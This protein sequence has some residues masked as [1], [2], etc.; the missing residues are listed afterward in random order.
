MTISISPKAGFITALSSFIARISFRIHW[1]TGQIWVTKKGFLRFF[2]K[3]IDKIIFNFSNFVLV[4]SESQKQFL[5]LNNIITNDK[6]TVLLNGSVG[7]VNIKKFKYKKTNR[8]FLRKKLN[9]SEDDFVFLYL[10]RINKD[11]GIID[12]IKA[13]EKLEEFYKAF[14]VLVGPIEELNLKN[15]I[16]KNKK[17][18]YVGKTK[19]PERWF[20]LAD[21]LCLPSYREGFGSVVIEAGSCNVPA[22]GSKIYGII[23]AIKENET[24]LLHKVGNIGDI[25]KKMIF[26]IR[27]KKLLKYYGKNARKRA[28]KSYEENL[29]GQEFLEFI[30]SKI[31]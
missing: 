18:I 19:T 11:K 12:I 27:N 7:G 29:V 31:N 4:D 14:L 13:F 22:L 10:G 5:I 9:I 21:I 28:E 30:N 15:Q 3:F 2:Y 16:K 6:S 20:P 24:G 25:K 8:N 26:V 1:F 23:D 17:V